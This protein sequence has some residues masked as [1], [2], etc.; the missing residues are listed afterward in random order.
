[1]RGVEYSPTLEKGDIAS[2]EGRVSQV[3]PFLRGSKNIK[4]LFRPSS[5]QG[6]SGK[7]PM[8]LL[9]PLF[10]YPSLSRIMGLIERKLQP[11]NVSG[12]FPPFLSLP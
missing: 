3:G 1:M 6:S 11:K 10:F 2:G 8:V 7:I 12:I 4:I 9:Y 5:G